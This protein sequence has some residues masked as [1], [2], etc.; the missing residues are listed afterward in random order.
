MSGNQSIWQISRVLCVVHVDIFNIVLTVQY[1][2]LTFL[3]CQLVVYFNPLFV[4]FIINLSTV[5][6]IFNKHKQN[7]LLIFFFTI[8][9]YNRCDLLHEKDNYQTI[10]SFVFFCYLTANSFSA[11]LLRRKAPVPTADRQ[12]QSQLLPSAL[13]PQSTGRKFINKNIWDLASYDYI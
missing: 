3:Y 10:A 5:D 13:L 6:V 9:I 4:I 2:R 7:P 1:M 12:S 11:F 8:Y